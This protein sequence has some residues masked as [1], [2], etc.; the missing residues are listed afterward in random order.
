[1]KNKKT[2]GILIAVLLLIVAGML[3]IMDRNKPVTVEGAK[4]ITL[5]VIYGDQT[6]KEFV[7]HTDAETLGDALIEEGLVTGDVGAYGLYVTAVDGVEALESEHQWWCFNDGDG[8]MLM[9]GIDQE[10]ILDGNKYQ[11]VLSVF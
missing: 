7:I 9:T 6:Q 8:N 3:L 11:A 10:P 5:T 1:M 4:E 2:V